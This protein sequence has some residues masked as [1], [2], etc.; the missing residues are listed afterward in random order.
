[1]SDTDGSGYL[2]ISNSAA[3]ALSLNLTLPANSTGII[4]L[5]V[6]I[7]FFLDDSGVKYPISNGAYN[8]MSIVDVDV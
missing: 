7:R 5:V 3:T 4:F 2:P 6:G 1:V 8:A